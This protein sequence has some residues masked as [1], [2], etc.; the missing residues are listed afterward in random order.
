MSRISARRAGATL[1]ITGGIAFAGLGSAGAVPILDLGSSAL[2]SSDV[3]SSQGRGADAPRLASVDNFRDVAGIG[4]GYALTGGGHLNKGVFYRSNVLQP[5]EADLVTLDSLGL[6]AVYDLRTPDA[7]TEDPDVVPAGVRYSNIDV[8]GRDLESEGARTIRSAVDARAFM[9]SMNRGFVVGAHER[10]AFAQLFTELANT[11]GPQVFHCNS[12]KDRTGW[13]AAVL[14]S[15]AGVDRETIMQDYL[16]T[17]EY[18]AG[19]IAR[20][21][22]ELT[23]AVGAERTEW[24][25]PMMGVERSYLE[26]G[27]AAL[28]AEYGTLDGYLTDGLGLSVDTVAKLRGKLVG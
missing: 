27:F 15:L 4:R 20:K 10:A 28:D 1:V 7:V 16:L 9:E 25:T 14:Q 2:G 3:G 12:G 26:A 11:E 17:N 8:F 21:T 13:A 23:A 22:E 6:S 19:T 5:S 24:Y 18:S